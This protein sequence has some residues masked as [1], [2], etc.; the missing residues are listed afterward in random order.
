MKHI[1]SS[2]HTHTH[3]LVPL[4]WPTGSFQPNRPFLFLIVSAKTCSWSC[5]VS[6]C[7]CLWVPSC[8]FLLPSISFSIFLCFSFGSSCSLPSSLF[9][10]FCL[11]FFFFFL[12]S[13]AL[14]LFLQSQFSPEVWYCMPANCC[15][16]LSPIMMVACRSITLLACRLLSMGGPGSCRV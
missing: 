12:P 14:T 7:R 16:S 11:Y 13:L 9:C 5:S 15:P 10:F 2:P 6:V 1:H 4:F 3:L 8:M